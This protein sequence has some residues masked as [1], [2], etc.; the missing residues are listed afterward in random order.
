MSMLTIVQHFCRRTG[1]PRPTTV[2]G[3][4]DPQVLQALA[5]LEEEG[6]ALASRHPWQALTFEA[7]H[8]SLAAEDQGAIATIA[9]NG[10]RRIKNE[11]IWNRTTSIPLYGPMD[12][13]EWQAVKGMAATGP[14]YRY[15]IRGGKLLANPTPTAGESWYFEYASKNWITDSTGVTYRQ[16]FGADTDLTLLEEDLL[17]AGLRWRWKKEKGFDYAQDFEDYEALIKDAMGGD[18]GKRTLSMDNLTDDARPRVFVAAGN[19]SVP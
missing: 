19:W 14:H 10:F 5:L 13:V 16:Y 1:I 8:T 18:G 3:G 9:S 11:T 4:T 15:R 6:N 17:L 2:Y 7:S 12:G